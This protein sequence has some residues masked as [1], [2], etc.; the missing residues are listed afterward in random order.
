MMQQRD[1][2]IQLQ[3][4]Y[5]ANLEALT[6]SEYQRQV[7][8]NKKNETALS[9][10]KTLDEKEIEKKKMAEDTRQFDEKLAEEKRQYNTTNGISE[11][12]NAG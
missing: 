11:P 1:N 2:L 4:M 12:V 8:E 10:L 7:A 9:Y 6:E 3:D 5:R